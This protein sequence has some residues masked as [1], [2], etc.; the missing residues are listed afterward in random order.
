MEIPGD[1]MSPRVSLTYPRH[2]D[3]GIEERELPFVA[4]ILADLGSSEDLPLSARHFLRIDRATFDDVLGSVAPR[5]RLRHDR[6]IEL[7]FRCLQDFEPEA[8]LR[9]SGTSGIPLDVVLHAPE[10]QRLEAAWQGIHHLVS[11]TGSSDAVRFR[12]LDVPS[13]LLRR[14]LERAPAFDHSHL[15][16]FPHDDIYGQSAGEPFGLLVADFAFS[17]QE[18]DIRMLAGIS[19]IAAAIHAPLVASASPRFFGFDDFPSL[20]AVSWKKIGEILDQQTPPAFRSFQASEDSRYA[21][22]VL[23]RVLL[24]PPYE[25]PGVG[26]ALWGNAAFVAAACITDSFVRHGWCSQIQGVEGGGFSPD[27]PMV[28]V[29]GESGDRDQIGSTDAAFDDIQEHTPGTHRFACLT[30]LK[31]LPGACFFVMPTCHHARQE[32]GATP[33]FSICH[34]QMRYVLPLSRFAHYLRMIAFT[35]IQPGISRQE[36]EQALNNWLQRYVSQ[37]AEGVFARARHPPR[38]ARVELTAE[39]RGVAFLRPDFLGAGDPGSPFRV[40]L[41]SCGLA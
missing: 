37:T 22:L 27:L 39:L 34:D 17:R 38:E 12:V 18:E 30:R 21:C 24:R 26:S 5:L 23:P 7:R 10:F 33:W 40:E 2:T 19:R 8:L 14:D 28:L 36:R 1:R 4:G 15:F 3:A 41:G 20:A 16:K 13:A 9:Q 11:N 29:P 25:K 6:E 31:G 32:Q 35:E